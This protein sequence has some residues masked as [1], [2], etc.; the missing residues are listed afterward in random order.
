MKNYMQ[1]T[2]LVTVRSL[3]DTDAAKSAQPYRSVR[4]KPVMCGSDTVPDCTPADILE[5]AYS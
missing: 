5:Q 3:I 4:L 1:M 2:V